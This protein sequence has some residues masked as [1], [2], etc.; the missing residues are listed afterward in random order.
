MRLY[1]NDKLVGEAPTGRE[2]QFKAVFTV[3]Y[4]PGTL[5]VEGVRGDRSV[6]ETTLTTVGRPGPPAD[7]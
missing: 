6:A 4:T 5:R 7:T 1:L 3:P 2:Q